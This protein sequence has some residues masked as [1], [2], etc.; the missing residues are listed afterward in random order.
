MPDFQ[1]K[2][3]TGPAS[4]TQSFVEL[5]GKNEDWLALYPFLELA[6]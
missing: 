2:G 5:D 1:I 6:G 3:K 4:E